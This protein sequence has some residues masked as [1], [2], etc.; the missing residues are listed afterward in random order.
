GGIG[1]ELVVHRM[2][3]VA[4]RLEQQVDALQA[5]LGVIELRLQQGLA[6]LPAAIGLAA[7]GVGLEI[8]ACDVVQAASQPSPDSSLFGARVNVA[9]LV[10]A[11]NHTPCKSDV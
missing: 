5:L 2:R 8:Q 9:G 1:D 7:A 10:D 11:W 4:D 3:A 6:E